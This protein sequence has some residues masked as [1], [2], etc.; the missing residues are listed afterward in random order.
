[1]LTNLLRSFATLEPPQGVAVEIDIVE[2][3]TEQN[4][5]GL[6]QKLA[7]NVP[8]KINHHWEPKLGIPIA[9]NH[10]LR[11]AQESEA[12][13]IIFIDDD[14]RV[15]RNWL[16]ELW[17]YYLKQ[18]EESIILGTVISAFESTEN[19]YLQHMMQ[20]PIRE[21]GYELDTC[22]T[23]N[24]LVHIDTLN[25][26]QL[27][28]DESRPLAGG[29]DSKLFRA[30]HRLNI[31]MIYCAEAIVYEDIPK[32]RVNMRWI[33]KRNFRAGLTYG[34]YHRENSSRLAFPLDRLRALLKHSFK[35]IIHTIAYNPEKRRKRWI[36]V[37]IASG[38]ILGFYKVRV[39]S[40]KNVN[41][42]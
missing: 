6:I 18:S 30:A 23:N 34:E 7:P 9:R 2:N 29:T 12:T 32:E 27:Q 15:A 4:L 39:D 8:F 31:P 13:H 5:C 38:Q 35:T 21:T 41:G 3:H 22:A 16:H 17:S 42:G 37:C 28:F 36:K 33:S 11:V 14:E 25:R 19:E 24:V 1:M 26:H 20:R 40:Y 10:G